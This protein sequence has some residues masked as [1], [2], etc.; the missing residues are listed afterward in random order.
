MI[1][2][3]RQAPMKFHGVGIGQDYYNEQAD[4]A[5]REDYYAPIHDVLERGDGDDLYRSLN[6][7]LRRTHQRDL[8]YKQARKH[9]YKTVDRRP[10]GALYYL[11]SGE[12]PK[13]EEEVEGP[14][15]RRLGGYNCEHVVP[16][17][18]FNKRHPMKSDLHHLFTEETRCNSSRANYNLAEVEGENLPSCG[19]VDHRG[20]E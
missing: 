19:I 16:Q 18:W 10:D 3:H 11:Y 14:N 7:L 17:S 1:Q 6:G 4:A 13:N 15:R 12:G 9:L 8:G 2:T 5:E 20:D